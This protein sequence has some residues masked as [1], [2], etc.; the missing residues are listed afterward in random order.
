MSL[1]VTTET[2]GDC[3]LC[4]APVESGA[5]II[6][7]AC[8]C[9]HHAKCL[10][11]TAN[12]GRLTACPKC[13]SRL[14]AA[15]VTFLSPGTVEGKK[16]SYRDLSPAATKLAEMNFRS[17][18]VGGTYGTDHRTWV[19]LVHQG[20]DAFGL[21]FAGHDDLWSLKDAASAR[22]SRSKASV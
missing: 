21:R 19:H 16:R 10:I 6:E 13:H 15:E 11:E 22:R 8:R 17:A 18:T 3:K 12:D 1:K 5:K 20:S 7:L 14:S 4:S 2:V 9:T